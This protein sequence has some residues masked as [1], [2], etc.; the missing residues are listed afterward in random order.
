M[1]HKSDEKCLLLTFLPSVRNA[2][3]ARLLYSCFVSFASFEREH[4]ARL[5]VAL[6]GCYSFLSAACACNPAILS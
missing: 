1:G 6:P 5:V 2:Q 3:G 4:W